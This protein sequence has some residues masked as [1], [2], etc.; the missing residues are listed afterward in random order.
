MALRSH[1]QE[2]R[3]ARPQ[4]TSGSRAD[5]N[6]G[7]ATSNARGVNSMDIDRPI[8]VLALLRSE[9]TK[10]SLIN[11]VTAMQNVG[12]RAGVGEVKKI[13]AANLVNSGCDL[14][15]LD[16]DLAD[17][18]DLS[19]LENLVGAFSARPPIVVTSSNPTVEGMRHLMRIGIAD[20]VPQPIK[21]S[22]L[23]RAFTTA[24]ERRPGGGPPQQAKPGKLICFMNA[25]GG[26]GA[27]TVAVQSAC[28][29]ADPKDPGKVVLLDLDIQYGN[30]AVYLDLATKSSV[31]DLHAALNRL[32]GSML[33]GAVARHRSGVDV[34]AAPA[35]IPDIDAVTPEGAA[36]LLHIAQ[37]EYRH[38]LVDMPHVWN[39][40]TRT[41]LGAADAIVLVFQA[42]VPSIRQARRQ[43]EL[44]A[45]EGLD[46]V[47][48]AIV[49]NR[50]ESGG[51]FRSGQGA[52]TTKDAAKA[53]G[54]EIPYTIPN[55]YKAILDAVNHGLPLA[56]VK[57]GKSTAKQIADVM[58]RILA[59]VDATQPQL[60]ANRP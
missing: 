46:G 22:D 20:L 7:E 49:L 3:I 59:Q 38:V 29:L 31:V 9:Q 44:L 36:R 8:D 24:I 27:T 58:K 6:I 41:V 56:E 14:L 50:A 48:L 19:M 37:R 57:G 23:I 54:R 55:D 39:R 52:V 18:S 42:T 4:A 32:D 17:G 33:R 21:R 53:L 13:D 30:I 2:P 1:D 5:G 25:C 35:T 10:E 40:W 11:V 47:P 12:I 16:I 26:M 43:A 34:L 60:A 15:L 28:S 45:E 51:L